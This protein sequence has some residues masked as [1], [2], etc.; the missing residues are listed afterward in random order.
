MTIK[1]LS[2]EDWPDIEAVINTRKKFQDSGMSDDLHD[3]LKTNYVR[4]RIDLDDVYFF[5]YYDKDELT[6]IASFHGCGA[7]W[8]I[9]VGITWTKA[10]VDSPRWSTSKF[11]AAST[12]ELRNYAIEYFEKELNLRII[13]TIGPDKPG[14]ETLSDVEGCVMADR[15]RYEKIEVCTI[16]AFNFTDQPFINTYILVNYPLPTQQVVHK[17]VRK[18]WKLPEGMPP[19]SE[20][21]TV[22]VLPP[23]E[24]QDIPTPHEL[25]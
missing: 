17:T 16:P 13:W 15:D 23:P 18:N 21:P 7:R 5:G 11:R 4:N 8:E 2:S 1:L 22:S 10:G 14:W 3:K 25:P 9:V 12:V 24:R 20:T 6:A 19:M